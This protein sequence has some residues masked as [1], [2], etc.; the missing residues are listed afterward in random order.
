M[1]DLGVLIVGAGKIAGRHAAAWQFLTSGRMAVTDAVEARAKHFAE[2]RG[3]DWEP[4]PEAA[5]RRPG[6]E[7]IDVC[8]PP[9]SI[10]NPNPPHVI[11]VE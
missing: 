2:S 11:S 10:H 3:I 8:S 6:Y 1:N 5:L 4:D 7:I 9:P